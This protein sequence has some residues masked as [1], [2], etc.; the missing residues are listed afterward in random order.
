MP[1]CGIAQTWI[2]VRA[3]AQHRSQPP[4]R[5][6][7]L[8]TTN[9]AMRSLPSPFDR[10][11]NRGLRSALILGALACAAT[12]QAAPRHD[13]GF[14]PFAE[15]AALSPVA[16]RAKAIAE[17]PHR[18]RA[19]KRSEEDRKESP[20]KP[21]AGPLTII[22]SIADQRLTVYGGGAQIAQAPIS[23]GMPGH[24]TPMGVFTVIQ[25]QKWHR[26]NIYSGAPMPFM[27]R[28]T[29]SGVAMHAGVLPGY[30][31]S[32]GCIRLPAD[33]A[34][35]FYGMTRLGARVIVAR[36][37]VAPVEISHPNLFA[38]KKPVTMAAALPMTTAQADLIAVDASPP[39]VTPENPDAA[40]SGDA[41]KPKD[42][43]VRS[44]PVSV[45]ISRKEKKL[46]VRQN[47]QTL[48]DMPVTIGNPEA[49]LGTHVFTAMELKDD[50]AAYRWSAVSIPSEYPRGGAA[51]E[52]GPRGGREKGGKPPVPA[53]QLPAAADALSRIDIP[54]DASDRISEMLSP[55]FSL[56][57]SDNGIS[58]ETGSDTDFVILTR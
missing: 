34:T 17:R 28:I 32:H 23:T 54:K 42:T 45:F 57:V 41:A 56:I 37:A 53:V 48:F 51:A 8:K 40:K 47:F 1:C 52:K 22:I 14:L 12:A 46:F 7:R 18:K 4:N 2:S 3:V 58:D 19:P 43:P 5:Q 25:K 27:Q 13:R 11:A 31:A 33:F 10:Y 49:P 15:P 38:P 50:G 24:P 36:N 39:T 21:P 30:P 29:W 55:G 9:L 6:F 35:R 20:A 26:S 44:G 16:D